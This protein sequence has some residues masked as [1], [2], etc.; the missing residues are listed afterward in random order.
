MNFKSHFGLV[1]INEYDEDQRGLADSTS[2]EYLMMP[3]E[4][5]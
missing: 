3:M 5:M 1:L 4:L 2:I